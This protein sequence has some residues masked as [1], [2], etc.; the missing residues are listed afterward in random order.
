MA[1][2]KYIPDRVAHFVTIMGV[3]PISV[4]ITSARTRWGSCSS[5]RRI[6]FSWRLMLA[7][8]DTID[9]VIIHELAHLIQLNHSK[10]FWTI[11]EKYAPD[12]KVQR[13]KLRELGKKL[14]E[15]KI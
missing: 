6:N 2:R 14:Y 15:A 5:K 11:V 10:A 12:Y 4:R 1:A 9:Y 7:E 3:S 8:E 13:K